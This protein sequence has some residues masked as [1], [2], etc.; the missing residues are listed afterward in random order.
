MKILRS[1]SLM[2]ISSAILLA[3]ALD[4][5]EKK[6]NRA[7]ELGDKSSKILLKTLSSNMKKHMHDGGVMD[8]F[9]FCSDKAYPLTEKVNK[10]LPSGIKVKRISLKF[11]NPANKPQED[12]AKVLE[13]IEKLKDLNVLLPEYFI[14]TVDTNTFKYYKPIVINNKACLKCHGD[15]SKN[16]DLKRAIENVYPIDNAKDYKMNDVR[17]AVVVTIKY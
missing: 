11:R 17:G 7:V 6:L 14:E 13:S 8:A 16:I 4:T 1:V 5:Q 12:E 2:A 3:G 10:T 15:V 9:N